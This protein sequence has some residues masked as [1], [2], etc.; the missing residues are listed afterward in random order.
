ME[1]VWLRTRLSRLPSKSTDQLAEKQTSLYQRITDADHNSR[2]V[3]SVVN[4]VLYTDHQD[5]RMTLADNESLCSQ[6]AEFFKFE[7]FK[8]QSRRHY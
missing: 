3:W 4:N 5:A 7:T 1:A 2:H 8:V 6:L